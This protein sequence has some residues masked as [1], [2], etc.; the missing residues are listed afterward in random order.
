MSI[1]NW[2][3]RV[4]FRLPFIDTCP[5]DSIQLSLQSS[6]LNTKNSFVYFS[7]LLLANLP[8]TCWNI[9]TFRVGVLVV[10]VCFCFPACFVTYKLQ[11]QKHIVFIL[12]YRPLLFLGVTYFSQL[13]TLRIIWPPTNSSYV[14]S[15]S[16]CKAPLLKITSKLL[17]I[18]LLSCFTSA[19]SLPVSSSLHVAHLLVYPC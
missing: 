18:K 3:Y 17:S 5:G 11:F 13:F 7:T 15:Y 2:D 14:L 8:R 6:V 4:T 16:L 19:L 12:V 1:Q 10:F 9:K